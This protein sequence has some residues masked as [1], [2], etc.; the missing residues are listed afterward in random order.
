MLTTKSNK[1]KIS[2]ELD[3]IISHELKKLR[4]LGNISKSQIKKIQ[5]NLKSSHR[6]ILVNRKATRDNKEAG[7]SRFNK[8]V[9]SIK[10]KI[11]KF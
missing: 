6:R 7:A 8:I 5:V 2:K 10:T 4:A 3:F 11:E 9:S 1:K